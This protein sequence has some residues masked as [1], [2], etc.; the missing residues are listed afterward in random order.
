MTFN[1]G[2]LS[3]REKICGG[4]DGMKSIDEGP[5][6]PS[7]ITEAIFGTSSSKDSEQQHL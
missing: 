2:K 1:L 6:Q 7:E 5:D 4:C 3:Q